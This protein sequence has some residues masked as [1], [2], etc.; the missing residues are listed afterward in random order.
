MNNWIVWSMEH[1]KWR[2]QGGGFTEFIEKAQHH[3]LDGALGALAES[4]QG[5]G[6]TTDFPEELMCPA[7]EE[8]T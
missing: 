3:T 5:L 1:R 8:T 6:T 2:K 7:P 4:N